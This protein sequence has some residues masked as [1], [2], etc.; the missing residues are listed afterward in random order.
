MGV[1]KVE[2]LNLLIDSYTSGILQLFLHVS[3][4]YVTKKTE[5]TVQN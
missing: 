4:S 3:L 5:R 2:M 1:T